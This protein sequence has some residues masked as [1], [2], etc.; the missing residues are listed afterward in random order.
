MDANGRPRRIHLKKGAES[1]YEEG[2]AGATIMPGMLIAL[3][4]SAVYVPHSVA[5]GGSEVNIAIEDA[6][7]GKTIDDAYASGDLVR[8]VIPVRGDVVLALLEAGQNVQDGTKL[9]SNGAGYVQA[10]TSEDA[11]SI[12]IALEDRNANDTGAV[13]DDQRIR[14]RVL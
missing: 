12:L 7:Q 6:L 11:D 5:D 8:F 1:V 13:I 14:C 10:Q 9:V 2:R 3:N 4:S